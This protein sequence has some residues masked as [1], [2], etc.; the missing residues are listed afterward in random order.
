MQ[1][2]ALHCPQSRLEK[3][4][5]CFCASLS[6][7]AGKGDCQPLLE[8]IIDSAQLLPP[9]PPYP[10]FLPE[11]NISDS[12]LDVPLPRL[13]YAEPAGNPHPATKTPSSSSQPAAARSLP[14]PR[15][16]RAPPCGR[17]AT[18]LSEAEDGVA[19]AFDS[20]KFAGSLKRLT[21][22]KTRIWARWDLSAFPVL[23]ALEVSYAGRTL[24]QQ[25]HRKV[26]F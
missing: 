26:G 13:R 21:A 22:R 24:L 15:S 8:C 1:A 4:L 9:P 20:P 25:L 18:P 6:S 17:V 14:T 7:Q 2:R 3:V 10:W 19:G 5:N 12:F 16:A 11:L 23:T